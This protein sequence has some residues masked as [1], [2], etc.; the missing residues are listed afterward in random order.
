[1]TN[2]FKFHVFNANKWKKNF[3]FFF[4]FPSLVHD[5]FA[6][7]PIVTSEAIKY[8]EF[9]QTNLHGTSQKIWKSYLYN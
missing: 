5:L 7:D 2:V 6:I 1:M 9:Q 3:V 4:V 8:E